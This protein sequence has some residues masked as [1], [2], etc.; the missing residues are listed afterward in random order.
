MGEP[1]FRTLHDVNFIKFQNV[2]LS[3]A[4][5]DLR[6]TM[7]VGRDINNVISEIESGTARKSN[8]FATG[9]ESGEKTTVGCSHK[10][11]IWEMNSSSIDYWVQW[12]KYAALKLNNPNI[13]L[14]NIL[15]NVMRSEKIIDAWPV[16]LFYADWPEVIAVENEQ[17]INIAVGGEVFNLLDTKLG[18]P[19]IKDDLTIELPLLALLQDDSEKLL[20]TISILLLADSYKYSCPNAKLIYKSEVPL[21]TY[22]DSNPLVLLKTDGSMI[23]GNYRYYSPVTVDVKLPLALIEAW[24]WQTT[25]IHKESMRAVADL[26]TVQGFT[27]QRISNLYD[28][29]FNDDGSGEIADLIGIREEKG[30]II[31]DLYHCKFCPQVDGAATPGARLSDVYEVCGQASRS[32]KWLHSGVKFFERLLYRYQHSLGKGFN[33]LLKGS[34]VQI[35]LLRNKCHDNEIRFGFS[36]VQP[37]ISADKIS[38][39]QL[40]VLGTSYTYIKGIAGVDLRVIVSR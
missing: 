21:N 23:E 34:P 39:E 16:G 17:K 32:I 3:R 10:G 24:D 14:H 9:F 6:F 8:I 2:G 36:I 20:T 30:L 22:L 29:V 40:T 37:A 5:K 4:R 31:I 12:C 33:R 38:D 25:R 19:V 27:F 7:H 1:T 35:D 11:K 26:D 18:K 13:D 28:I 15:Q